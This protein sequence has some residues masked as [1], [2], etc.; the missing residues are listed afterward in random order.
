[1]EEDQQHERYFQGEA[2]ILWLFVC[3]Y[4]GLVYDFLKSI[5][6]FVQ[7]IIRFDALSPIDSNRVQS[8][9]SVAILQSLLLS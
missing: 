6:K 1:M 8:A 5:L 4:H 3:R 2:L 7:L 9:F